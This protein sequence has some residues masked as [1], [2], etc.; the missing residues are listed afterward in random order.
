MPIEIPI[1]IQARQQKLDIPKH[2][3]N[4]LRQLSNNIILLPLQR[5]PNNKII[6]DDPLTIIILHM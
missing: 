6:L 2:P 5:R 4:N 3:S 1:K